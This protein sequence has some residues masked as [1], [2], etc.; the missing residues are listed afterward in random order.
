MQDRPEQTSLG[1]E[2]T[3]MKAALARIAFGQLSNV[4]LSSVLVA[5]FAGAA[6][7][8]RGPLELVGPWLVLSYGLSAG[9]YALGRIFTGRRPS[10]AEAL[11]WHA[12]LILASLSSGC[13]WAALPFLAVQS[14]DSVAV[15]VVAWSVPGLV[16]GAAQ[17]H[18]ASLSSFAA[19]SMPM[20]GSL[21]WCTFAFPGSGEGPLLGGLTVVYGVAVS[22]ITWRNH[23]SI[24]DTIALRFENVALLSQVTAERNHAVMARLEAERAS[25]AKT[26]FLAAASHDLRQPIHAQALF[27]ETLRNRSRDASTSYLIERAQAAGS[28]L[29]GL[30]DALL[31]VSRLDAGALRVNPR[32]IQTRPLLEQLFR[33]YEPL[34]V[35]KGLRLRVISPD[36]WVHTDPD[37]LMRILG[38]LLANAIAYTPSGGVLVCCRRRGNSALFQVWDS[39][40]GIPASKQDEIFLE[41][42]Q[43]DNPERDRAKGIGLGLAIVKRLAKLLGTAVFV[44]SVVGRGS[45]FAFDFPIAIAPSPAP[46]EWL[47]QSSGEAVLTRSKRLPAVVPSVLTSDEAAKTDARQ[48]L[49]L[50]VLVIDDD[51][52]AREG[53][54]S[55]LE[56]W[57][58]SVS[59]AGSI[60]EAEQENERASIGLI[61]ADYRL[62][63]ASTG[64]EAIRRITRTSNVPALL[65][66]GD[67]APQRIQEAQAAGYPLLHKPIRPQQLLEV[68]ERL[69]GPLPLPLREAPGSQSLGELRL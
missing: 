60:E 41:F 28:A 13:L 55:L 44:R 51:V 6:L 5:T 18:A 10:D 8:R 69:L 30:L 52:L 62:R 25:A 61:I 45:V 64:A 23:C 47:A 29:Q 34:A 21:A 26:Q 56:S 31:D 67:T 12:L 17:S 50:N 32:A 54:A 16:A 4:A 57:G 27:L 36:L 38:N 37:A 9:R 19:A 20:L 24:R 14:G 33:V 58:F 39:G 22:R 2:S 65:I 1:T 43:L 40:V 15:S 63:Q 7:L 68:L 53:M 3:P 49:L 11:R 66:T 42:H 59:R 46:G 35:G 48:R